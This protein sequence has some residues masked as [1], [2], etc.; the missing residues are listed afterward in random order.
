V[1]TPTITDELDALTG[2]LSDWLA[3]GANPETIA[4]LVQDRYQRDRVVTGLSERGVQVRAVD[5]ERPPAGRPVVM[6]MHRAKGTE[7]SRVVLVGV[8]SRS[9][10]EQARLEAMDA[11]ERADA[12]LRE[13]SLTYVAATRARDELVVLRRD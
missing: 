3:D 13:R 5:R 6:T 10:A 2:I 12:E 4:T 9:S 7:F 1:D 8:G 11:A